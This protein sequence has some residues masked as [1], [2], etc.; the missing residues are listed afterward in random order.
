M[1]KSPNAG[2]PEAAMARALNISLAG[3]RSYDGKMR[4][5]AWVN[6]SARRDLDMSDIKKAVSMLWRV[7]AALLG[8]VIAIACLS[9]AQTI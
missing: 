6:E 7:W 3:P 9:T 8:L 1:H 4:D 5:L 2:W